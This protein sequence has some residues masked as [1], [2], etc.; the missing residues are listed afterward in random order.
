MDGN[1]KIRRIALAGIV[2]FALNACKVQAPRYVGLYTDNLTSVTDTISTDETQLVLE[3]VYA[4]VMSDTAAITRSISVDESQS[5]E[6][7]KITSD[8]N[9]Q[10]QDKELHTAIN[11]SVQKLRYQVME[12][13]KQLLVKSDTT[14]ENNNTTHDQQ[15]RDTLQYLSDSTP[16]I[17]AKN[18][19]IDMMLNHISELEKLAGLKSDTV[20]FTTE[21]T[22]Q[23]NEDT[24]QTGYLTSELFISQRDT[25]NLLRQQVYELQN[26]NKTQSDPAYAN[27]TMEESPSEYS[28]RQ[29]EPLSIQP[30]QSGGEQIRFQQNSARPTQNAISNTPVQNPNARTGLIV[31]PSLSLQ[32]GHSSKELSE[33]KDDTT[34]IVQSQNQNLQDQPVTDTVFINKQTEKNDSSEVHIPD[35]LN[36]DTIQALQDTIQ[37]LTDRLLSLEEEK[38][39]YRDTLDTPIQT[40]ESIVGNEIKTDTILI[41]AN[42]RM[43]ELKP[44]KEDYI[45]RQIKEVLENKRAAKIILSGYTDSSGSKSVNKKMTALRLDYIS[46]MIIPWIGKENIY[47]QNFGDAFASEKIIDDERRVEIRILID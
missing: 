8:N 13:Q 4:P 35:S 25:I 18:D 12:L 17:E 29:S 36:T 34:K 23:F 10:F 45:L 1:K 44:L 16:Q 19:T 21:A 3:D 9:H 38:Y 24:P 6:L 14:I 40:E 37:L 2:L 46:E 20:F 42:Y 32:A 15:P 11:Y 41:V 22:K 39:P 28:S 43:G 7:F 5:E 47:F 33:S 31:Q 30:T 26:I 27:K